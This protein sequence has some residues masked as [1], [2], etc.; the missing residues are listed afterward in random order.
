MTNGER[1]EPPESDDP[2][3]LPGDVPEPVVQRRRRW[4]PSLV[5]LIPLLAAVIGITLAIKSV[6]DRGPTITISFLS[7]E[8]IDASKTQVKYK[9]VNIG[10]V[11]RITLSQDRSHVLVEV[12]LT[13]QAE[14]F[15]VADTR[16]W[17]V[18]PRVAA[19]GVSGLSTLL[20]GSYIGVDAGHSRE[21]R[22]EFTGLEQPPAVT[23][24]EKGRQFVLRG[25]SLGSLDIGSPV[26]YR[27]VTVGQVVGYDMNRDGSGVTVRVFINAP[28]DQY[29]RG[30]TR[31][32]QASGIAVRLDANGIKLDTQSLAAILAGGVAFQSPPSQ[33]QGEPTRENTSYR[34]AADEVEAMRDPDGVPVRVVMRFNQSLRGL[35]PGA[36]VDFRGITLGKVVSIGI[37]YDRATKT[38]SMPVAVDLYPLRLGT[39]FNSD[40]GLEAGRERLSAMVRHGLRAQLRSGNLLT[41][42]LYIALDFFP[43]V[44]PAAIDYAKDPVELPTTPST[45][46][47]LQQ[48]LADIATKLGKVPFDQIGNN[49]NDTLKNANALFGQLSTEL[50][51]QAKQTLDEAQKTFKS[52]NQVLQSDSPLQTDVARALQELNRTMQSL[53][54]LADYLER[55][56]ESLL[57]GKP[58]DPQLDPQP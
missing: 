29:V 15:A 46:D 5:W 39:R 8:G 17:V 18:R 25:D 37:E 16:F 31:F 41:G 58:Q 42:Q 56:P 43:R 48:Q 35:Q 20:S 55:H 7:A 44:P 34:L 9:N 10:E 38:I 33:P 30:N 27:R 51:P 6:A 47:E 54:A 53:N 12:E 13:K 28:Y 1:P 19:T 40:P 11:K 45:L 22:R 3:P 23:G 4:L 21:E 52:A 49:L 2:L 24:D 36:P 50:A 14:N 57:R 26:F 32:W